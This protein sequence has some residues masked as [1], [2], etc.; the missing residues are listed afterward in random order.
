V[1]R[2]HLNTLVVAVGAGDKQHG[3]LPFVKFRSVVEERNQADSGENGDQ[4][5]QTMW[6]SLPESA[7]GPLQTEFFDEV[8]IA[9]PVRP[10]PRLG[11]QAVCS[12]P[13]W[14]QV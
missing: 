12:M 2:I 9:T 14:R 5:T 8:V 7:L 4:T 10:L 6:G 11:G 3:S 1:K 13:S